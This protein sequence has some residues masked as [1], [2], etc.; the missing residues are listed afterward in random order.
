MSY[1]AEEPVRRPI[2]RPMK[3]RHFLTILK[4][5]D[6]YCPST[7]VNYGEKAGFLKD[8]PESEYSHKR[9][10]IRHALARFTKN[11]A[12]PYEGDGLTSELIRGQS[13]QRGWLGERWKAAALNDRI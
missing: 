2:G 6:I 7:I 9:R 4:D 3:Y 12:F 8:I 10:Q 1:D 11:H 5:D 13:P